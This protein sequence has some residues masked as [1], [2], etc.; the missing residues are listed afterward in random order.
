MDI[1]SERHMERFIT[2]KEEE[3]MKDLKDKVQI[4]RDKVEELHAIVQRLENIR[5]D[6]QPGST[7]NGGSKAG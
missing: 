3:A 2:M 7:A 5:I 6:Q 4:A 1:R